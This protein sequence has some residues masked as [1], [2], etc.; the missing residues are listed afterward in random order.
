MF[1]G[2]ATGGAGFD[3]IPADLQAR[4]DM[5]LVIVLTM[6][7]FLL[8]GGLNR[9]TLR[10]HGRAIIAIFVGNLV[11]D[12]WHGQ[13]GADGVGFCRSVFP[14][15]MPIFSIRT[16]L[17]GSMLGAR[18]RERM[19]GF[20]LSRDPIV[21]ENDARHLLAWI[22]GNAEETDP[23]RRFIVAQGRT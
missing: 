1:I 8:G 19:V 7:A 3:L 6:V 4:Y 21:S 16:F 22:Q 20:R 10:Q 17:D 2:L 5:L 11:G 23:R 15:P 13:F 14:N 12:A 18:E 9:E